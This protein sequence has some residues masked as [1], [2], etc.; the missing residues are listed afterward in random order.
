MDKQSSK[1]TFIFAMIVCIVC[2][3]SL[4]LVSEGLRPRKE[5]NVVLDIKKNILKA[6]NL[7]N[8][9][10]AKATS[11]DIIDTYKNKIEEIVLDDQGNI[12]EGKNPKEIAEGWKAEEEEFAEKRRRYLIYS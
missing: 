12:I 6:V 4:S 2:S 10:G 9:L 7:E 11:D 1:Y 8:P 3:V 5:L